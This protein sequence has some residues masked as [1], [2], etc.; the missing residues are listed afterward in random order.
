MLNDNEQDQL[1]KLMDDLTFESDRIGS[2]LTNHSEILD[3]PELK[4]VKEKISD[5]QG[6][7]WG[8]IQ[9]DISELITQNTT[10]TK[11]GT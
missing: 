9:G 4:S 1:R 10:F 3:K 11:A 2:I 5:I 8:G 6:H 7:L